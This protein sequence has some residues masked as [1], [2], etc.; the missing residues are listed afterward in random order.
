MFNNQKARKILLLLTLFS[1]SLLVVAS[2]A[3]NVLAQ[4]NNASLFPTTVSAAQTPG[5]ISTGKTWTYQFTYRNSSYNGSFT[6]TQQNSG[7]EYIAD[8]NYSVQQCYNLTTTIDVIQ[9]YTAYGYPSYLNDTQNITSDTQITC[10]YLSTTD[11]SIPRMDILQV[12]GYN[13]HTSSQTFDRL[14]FD[15]PV[16][17]YA[18]P[19]S[20]GQSWHNPA[21]A[22]IDGWTV[23][24]TSYNQTFGPSPLAFDVTASVSGP[25]SV[26]VPAGTYNTYQINNNTGAPILLF[27]ILAY[28]FG[29]LWLWT[30]TQCSYSLDA[31]NFVKCF[32]DYGS[33]GNWTAE[34]ISTSNPLQTMQTMI[35]FS[36]DNYQQQQSF[37][38]LLLIGGG[39]GAV[40][41]IAGIAIAIHRR[42]G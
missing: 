6:Y 14:L 32:L 26:T 19:L 24:T 4:P 7:V 23:N 20:N 27:G 33:G 1:L 18:F 2:L 5:S 39:I 15:V 21:T 34:L 41:V 40:I 28:I 12:F 22:R 31:Q 25:T 42:R 8:Y 35:F 38:K 10:L 36:F 3:G 16:N 30:S 17:L 37:S 9:L 13:N 11:Y 29:P